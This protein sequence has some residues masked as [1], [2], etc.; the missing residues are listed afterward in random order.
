VSDAAK[1]ALHDQ[2]AAS[3][4]ADMAD[5]VDLLA[6]PLGRFLVAGGPNVDRKWID[7]GLAVTGRHRLAEGPSAPPLEPVL[8]ADVARAPEDRRYDRQVRDGHAH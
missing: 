4:G 3:G 6:R 5:L 2:S 7:A 8:S 1:L